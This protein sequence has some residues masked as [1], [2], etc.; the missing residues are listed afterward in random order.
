MRPPSELT[1]WHVEQA[2]VRPKKTV[3]PRGASPAQERL[4]LGD[5]GFLALA[6]L[7]EPMEKRGR[8]AAHVVGIAGQ[9]AAQSLRRQTPESR[10]L[11]QRGEQ[12]LGDGGVLGPLVGAEQQRQFKWPGL[13]QRRRQ[14]GEL[15][16]VEPAGSERS[17]GGQAEQ[18]RLCLDR[19]GH[20]GRRNRPGRSRPRAAPRRP[21]PRRGGPRGGTESLPSVLR[22][23]SNVLSPTARAEE[24]AWRTTPSSR[25]RRLRPSASVQAGG[26]CLRG[27]RA[28]ASISSSR[29]GSGVSSL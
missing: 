15:T 9:R 25:S 2:A 18:R 11:G 29:V 1:R 17:S 22:T 19:A 6:T 3:R 28:I 27:A 26:N 12:L 5:P 8:C 20:G 24:I 16:V 21:R 10:R 7:L 13:G 14:C 23:P 4:E